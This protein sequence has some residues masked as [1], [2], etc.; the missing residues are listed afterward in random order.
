MSKGLWERKQGTHRGLQN[1]TSQLLQHY[2]AISLQ[3]LT[4]VQTISSAKTLIGSEKWEV[5]EKYYNIIEQRE[6]QK[7]EKC[8]WNASH[9]APAASLWTWGCPSFCRELTCSL[10]HLWSQAEAAGGLTAAKLFDIKSEDSLQEEKRECLTHLQ[11]V[12]F[13]RRLLIVY[14]KW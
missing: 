7:M 4:T 8:L 10:S 12:P 13:G 9:P 3:I 2:S 5:K 1:K 11:S 6:F 14:L